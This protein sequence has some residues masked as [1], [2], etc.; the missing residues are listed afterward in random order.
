MEALRDYVDE[1]PVGKRR[2]PVLSAD[3][4]EAEKEDAEEEE[5]EFDVDTFASAELDAE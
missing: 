1:G 2:L 4:V 3:A 5:E